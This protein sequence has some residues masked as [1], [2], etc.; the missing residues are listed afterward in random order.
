M[1]AKKPPRLAGLGRRKKLVVVCLAIVCALIAV[2]LYAWQSQPVPEAGASVTTAEGKSRQEIQDELDAIVRDNM[3]T[4]SVAPVAQLQ[5]DGKLRVNVQNVQD[6]KFPQRFRVIQ[7]D[8][9][10]YE[11]GVVETG[12]TIETCPAGDIKEGEAYI[13]IQALDAKTSTATAIQHV[14]RYGLSKPRTSF[15]GRRGTA[16]NS[17]AFVQ[18]S[19]DGPRRIERNNHG[20]HQEH[21]RSQSARRGRRARAR[22]RNGRRPTP[23]LA[24]GRVGTTKVMVRTEID[25][26]EFKVP[27]V[28]PFVAKADGTLQGPS[29]DATTIDNHSAYGIHVTNMKIDAM[30]TWTIAAD[31]K[32]GTAQNSIDF[33]VGPDG[34]LQNASA[35]MQETGLDLSKNAAFDMGYQGIAGGTDKIKLKTSGNVAR[36]TRDIFRVTGEGDQVATI[37]WTVEPGAHTA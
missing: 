25:N 26:V 4:I 18:S 10:M 28:I 21:E 14:S 6:N 20:H 2:G 33:K 16:R 23:A 30:N 29:E 37:T 36:V 34:A 3:M 17:P 15:F 8:E 35:A 27:T 1:S 22:A 11:S 7:N 5:E 24:A 19:R 9:T 31:A 13:E 12:K 32:A